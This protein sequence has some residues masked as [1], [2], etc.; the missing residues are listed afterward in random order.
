MSS[1]G[2]DVAARWFAGK[3]RTVAAVAPGGGA[4]GLGLL[5]VVY[6]D[7]GAERYLDIPDGFAWVPLLERLVEGPIAGAGGELVLRPGPALDG[8]RAAGLAG[9]RVPATDQSNTL[10][11]LGERLLVKAYRRLEPGPHPEVELLTALAGR[12]APVPPFA[13]S[14]VWRPDDGG[15]DTAIA[16]LQALVPGAEDGWEP[17]IERAADALRA[18]PPYATGEWAAA[19][20]TAG[21]LHT[22]LADAFGLAPATAGDLA[23]WRADAEAAL[24][25]A[26]AHDAELAAAAPRVRSRL[27]A[28]TESDP[29]LLTRI[30]GDLHVGQLLRQGSD[31]FISAQHSPDPLVIDFEGDPTRP[32]ADRLRPDTP[33]RD[34][35]GLLRCADH[36]GSA[37]SRRAGDADPARWIEAVSGAALAAYAAAAPVPVDPGL[38]AALELAKECSEFVYAQR[39]AP[40]WLYAPQ[41]GMRRLLED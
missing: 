36:I 41:R 3:S 4:A 11:A 17:P 24:T 35:A 29:P 40:E 1:I 9:E 38:L 33:L 34:L 39:V 25:E 26:A 8:L 15:A 28:L 6:A 19:G 18:G 10:V 20:R 23:R 2:I 27:S 7:G 12:P 14:L 22:A 13:G 32:L 31:P 30:H 16:V 5:D 37:G 21:R